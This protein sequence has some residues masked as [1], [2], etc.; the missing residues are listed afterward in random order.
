MVRLAVLT[1]LGGAE[2]QCWPGCESRD[3]PRRWHA[4][5]RPRG[6][7]GAATSADGEH[8]IA[9]R[10]HPMTTR[11]QHYVWRKYLEAWQQDSG[12]IYCSRNG[13]RTFRSNPTKVMKKRDYYS[14]PRIRKADVA[15]LN[16]M[17]RKTHPELRKAHRCLIE[18]IAVHR[19]R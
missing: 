3:N 7:Q 15:F 10:K 1:G 2:V 17:F 5:G 4:H 12:Q 13:G 11:M 14:L 9:I 6:Q 19:K 18:S 8:D 16:I